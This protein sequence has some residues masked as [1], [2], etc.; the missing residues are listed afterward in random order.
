MSSAADYQAG[1]RLAAIVASSDDA[2][3]SKDLTGKILTWNRGAERIFGYTAEEAIGQSITVIIPTERLSEETEVLRRICAG[4]SVEHFETVRRRKDGRLIDIS[5]TVSPIVSASGRIVGASKIARDITEQKRLQR[6]AA[7]ANRLKDEFLATLS[8][9]LRTPL[10]AVLG[11]AMLLDGGNLPPDQHTRAAAAIRRNAQ[12][13]ARLVDDLLDTSRIV[14]GKMRLQLGPCDVAGLVRE[15]IEMVRQ[16][17]EVKRLRLDVSIDGPAPL[18]A[19]CDRL[20]QVLWNLLTNAVKF[21]PAG[22]QVAVRLERVDGTIRIVVRDTGI[23]ISEQAMP[24]IFHRFWQEE[25]TTT[26]E[27]NGLGLGLALS[28][29]LVELHGGTI[30]ADSAG[31]GLGS[32]FRIELPGPQEVSRASGPPGPVA[33]R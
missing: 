20:R 11:Y 16:A 26:R 21:T 12:A 17:I 15:S 18:E 32:E 3:V 8:H 23:G 25:T 9:E 31:R 29:Y 28:R 13:L 30:T 4:D 2:I 6:E 22:G 33:P 24:H 1:D 10:N 27:Y 19:D 14:T 7:E 5:L